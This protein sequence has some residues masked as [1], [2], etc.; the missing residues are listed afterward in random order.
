MG[1]VLSRYSDEKY[2]YRK[3]CGFL[4]ILYFYRS[5]LRR[6]SESR[7]RFVSRYRLMTF[8]LSLHCL[9]N[10]RISKTLGSGIALG[11]P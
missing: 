2:F 11:R 10:T 5:D 6:S 3:S 4:S 8:V 1:T 7:I 9:E